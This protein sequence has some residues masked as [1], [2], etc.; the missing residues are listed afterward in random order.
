MIGW[1][2]ITVTRDGTALSRTGAE[3]SVAAG[4][5]LLLLLVGAALVAIRRRRNA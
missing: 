3:V 1:D 2:T 5:A 4:A